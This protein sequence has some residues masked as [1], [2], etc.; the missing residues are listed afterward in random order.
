[1]FKGNKPK[2]S[3]PAEPKCNSIMR[4][5]TPTALSLSHH[6]R[7]RSL[8]SRKNMT[9]AGSNNITNQVLRRKR[10]Y[11]GTKAELIVLASAHMPTT[12]PRYPS[13][14]LCQPH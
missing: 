14:N 12:R 2:I 4:T 9:A 8:N 13:I 6:M 11:K 10:V 7:K 1:M 3:F 5:V